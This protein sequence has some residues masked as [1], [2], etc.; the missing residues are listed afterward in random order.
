MTN[1]S[2]TGFLGVVTAQRGATGHLLHLPTAATI[3]LWTGNAPSCLVS[4]AF[5][6][7]TLYQRKASSNREGS[8]EASHK[9]DD[10]DTARRHIGQDTQSVLRSQSS[11]RR[12]LESS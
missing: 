9:S 4:P 11:S 6:N 8:L 5:A 2:V 1:D 3:V 7:P 10:A 12:R